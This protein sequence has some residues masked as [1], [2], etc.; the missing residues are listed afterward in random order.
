MQIKNIS[1]FFICIVLFIVRLKEMNDELGAYLAAA[2]E[3]L[4]YIFTL[5]NIKKMQA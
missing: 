1:I 3:A 2:F 4:V 5:P